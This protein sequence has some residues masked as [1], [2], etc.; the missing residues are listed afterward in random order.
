MMIMMVSYTCTAVL[1]V[2]LKHFTL[3]LLQ[4]A[5]LCCAEYGFYSI[6]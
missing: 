2:I 1:P 4:A 6:A 3:Y 5:V